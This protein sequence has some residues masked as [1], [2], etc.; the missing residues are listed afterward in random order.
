[1]NVRMKSRIVYPKI[2]CM[3]GCVHDLWALFAKAEG[4]SLADRHCHT[5]GC[6]AGCWGCGRC[7]GGRMERYAAHHPW[8]AAIPRMA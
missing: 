3:P 2:P 1:M 6:P 7:T 8:E 5:P 4:I